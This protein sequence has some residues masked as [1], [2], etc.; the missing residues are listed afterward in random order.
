M[1]S[2]SEENSAP[3]GQFLNLDNIILPLVCSTVVIAC[4]VNEFLLSSNSPTLY[5]DVSNWSFVFI[6]DIIFTYALFLCSI[7]VTIFSVLVLSSLQATLLAELREQPQRY[8]LWNYIFLEICL[9]AID[10]LSYYHHHKRQIFFYLVWCTMFAPS[11]CLFDQRIVTLAFKETFLIIC[12]LT[13]VAFFWNLRIQK[14]LMHKL[15]SVF[16]GS[17]ILLTVVTIIVIVFGFPRNIFGLS[18]VIFAVYGGF[19]MHIF[20]FIISTHVFVELT[21]RGVEDMTHSAIDLFVCTMHIFGRIMIVNSY[22][23][24]ALK[25]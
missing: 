21:K 14:Y 7:M 4:L 19:L 10:R 11:I 3:N 12:A 13:A 2:V 15:V 1:L 20:L 23:F 9:K 8:F 18:L 5:D 25:S 22:T 6:K 24:V 16:I 17:Y